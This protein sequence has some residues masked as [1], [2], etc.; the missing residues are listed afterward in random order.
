MKRALSAVRALKVRKLRP[1]SVFK[2]STL[3]TQPT[4]TEVE[5]RL[6]ALVLQVA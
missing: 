4:D 1:T 3:V 2:L 5:L 6:T